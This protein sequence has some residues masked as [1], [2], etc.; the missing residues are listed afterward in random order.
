MNME[1]ADRTFDTYLA[2]IQK[3][4]LLTAA[5]EKALARRVQNQFEDHVDAMVAK[6][7]M[8]KRN[9]RLVISVAKKYRGRG[10]TLPDL[11]EEGNLGLVHAV[12]KF[13][14][15]MD[16]RFSTY[17]TWWIRQAIRRSVMN[18]VKTVRTPTYL[19]E[20]LNRWRAF[21][22]KFEHKHGRE[23][24]GEEVA[25]AM[26]PPPGRRRMLLRLYQNT[27]P[28]SA[29]VFP[30]ST[31]DISTAKIGRASCRERV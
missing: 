22:R 9:L 30:E 15:E 27:L 14:P 2:E 6:D 16:T 28:G 3:F 4:P 12:E 13:D 1:R 11:V 23:P 10:L 17:A 26:E 31:P 5:E 18:T 29:T 24:T 20:D 25:D 19:A 8:I 7:E 21:A